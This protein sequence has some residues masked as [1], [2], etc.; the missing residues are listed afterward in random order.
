MKRPRSDHG[1]DCKIV[2]RR[3]A[4]ANLNKY[5]ASTEQIVK[6]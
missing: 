6:L 3:L 2:L 5:G 1:A 4:T